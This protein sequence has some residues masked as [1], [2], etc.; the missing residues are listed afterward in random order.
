[1][2]VELLFGQLQVHHL[3]LVPQS[4][5]QLTVEAAQCLAARHPGSQFRLHANVRVLEQH[6]TADLSNLPEHLDWF[7]QAA[8]VSQALGAAAYSAHAGRRA[9]S[10]LASMFDNVRK[11]ADLFGCP[12]AVEGLYPTPDDSFLLSTWSEYQV[13]LES[14]VLFALDLSHLNIL[15]RQSGRQELALVQELL[16]SER[17]IEIHVS[18]NDGRSD[19]HRVCTRSTWW[20][21][22]LARINPH[23]V[24]FSEGNHRLALR[25][26]RQ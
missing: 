17:C 5:G 25:E 3:Q 24:I 15:A 18:D 23:A 22:L 9:N 19:L 13:L 12:V 20:M 2:L 16:A 21:P 1:M 11:A 26:G 10:T 7:S 4:T 6:R 14:G 8:R